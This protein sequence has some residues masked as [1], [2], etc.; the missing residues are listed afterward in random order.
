M[1]RRK[2][3]TLFPLE[4]QILDSGLALQRE[5]GTFYG[6]ALAKRLAADNDQLLLSG[7]GTLYKAL[8]RMAE[9]GLLE[10]S[11]E[12]S[13]VAEAENRPRRREY[14]V[15]GAGVQS[16]EREHERSRIST[17]AWKVSLA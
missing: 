16:L 13:E 5:A 11:W 9:A 6:F 14:I 3:G 15:T 12:D 1:P 8:A 7:H 17:R 10:S 4:I 2:P